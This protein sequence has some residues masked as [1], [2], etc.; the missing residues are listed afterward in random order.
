MRPMAKLLE[1][2]KYVVLVAVVAL[3][4]AA[5]A[6]FGWGAWKTISFVAALFTS[7]GEAQAI[8]T[9]LDMMDTFLIGTVLFIFSLGLY[10]LFIGKLQTPEWLEIDDL[11]KLKAKLSDV[12]VLFMAIK[13]LDKLLQAKD[14]QDV[15]WYALSVAVVSAVL[16]AFNRFRA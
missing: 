9:L 11:S 10:E 15:F 2:S 13:F 3:M 6:T 8:L 1:S 7:G 14:Y 16:I 5:I 12:I 4:A